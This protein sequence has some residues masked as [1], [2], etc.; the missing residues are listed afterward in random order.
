[1]ATAEFGNGIHKLRLAMLVYLVGSV[2]GM[3]GGFVGLLPGLL[4]PASVSAAAA[5]ATVYLIVLIIGLVVGLIAL[6]LMR[7]GFKIVRTADTS[8]GIGVTGTLLEMIGIILIG[9]AVAILI[10]TLG[11]AALSG[12][13]SG[14]GGLGGALVGVFATIGLIVIGA[15]IAFVGVILTLVGLFRIGSKYK[16]ALVEI[17][18]VLYLF[19]TFVGVILLYIGL[20]EIERKG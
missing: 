5:S 12:G 19:I 17:G 10:A 6:L 15:I 11:S 16:N 8:Y 18:A 13:I 14:A 1:M 20:G 4:S 3:V 2:L 9:V 7:S